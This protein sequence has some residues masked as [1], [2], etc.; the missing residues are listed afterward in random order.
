ML[1]LPFL[2]YWF[3]RRVLQN[4]AQA[5][6]ELSSSGLLHLMGVG[7]ITGIHQHTRPVYPLSSF[8]NFAYTAY[9]CMIKVSR[10]KSTQF[11]T[12]LPCVLS[13]GNIL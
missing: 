11:N 7:M 6:L 13:L 1:F 3:V 8:Q 10:Y 5:G 2:K 12:L 4:V 9:I